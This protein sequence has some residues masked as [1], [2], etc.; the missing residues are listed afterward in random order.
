MES[1]IAVCWWFN[2][3]P[4]IVELFPCVP[5]GRLVDLVFDVDSTFHLLPFYV[6]VLVNDAVFSENVAWNWN[7]VKVKW[8]I[9]AFKV[10]FVLKT[11]YRLI[12]MKQLFWL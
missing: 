2:G 5:I 9:N 11:S 7:L 1:Y 6:A 12:V 10:Y 3:I 4:L 8:E